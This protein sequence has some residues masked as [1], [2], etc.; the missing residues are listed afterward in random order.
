MKM[1]IDRSLCNHALPT[2][3]RCFA[4]VLRFP[5]GLDRHCITEFEDDGDPLLHLTV[6]YDDQVAELVLTPEE[7]ELA[8]NLGWSEFVAVMPAFYRD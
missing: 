2:C 3:E 7:R 5:L 4:P 6:H 1:V 8:A